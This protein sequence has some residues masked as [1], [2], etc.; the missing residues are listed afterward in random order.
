[1]RDLLDA[2]KTE[3]T[4]T[5]TDR[6]AARVVSNAL[7]DRQESLAKAELAWIKGFRGALGRIRR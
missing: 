1:V 4:R 6:G 7:L 5:A 3:R 2:V